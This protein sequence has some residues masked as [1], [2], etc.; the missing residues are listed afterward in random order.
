MEGSRGL[1]TLVRDMIRVRIKVNI[2]LYICIWTFIFTRCM[3]NLLCRDF[4]FICVAF[5]FLLF[6]FTRERQGLFSAA[7]II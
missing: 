3:S 7:L 5:F 1:L 4:S 6:G 2:N